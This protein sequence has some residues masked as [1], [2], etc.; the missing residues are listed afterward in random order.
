MLELPNIERLRVVFA[1]FNDMLP[2]EERGWILYKTFWEIVLPICGRLWWDGTLVSFESEYDSGA[3]NVNSRK[4]GS[5]KRDFHCASSGSGIG[6]R[7][8]L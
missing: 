8:E 6:G 3:G 1:V 4:L 5:G 7:E 2:S